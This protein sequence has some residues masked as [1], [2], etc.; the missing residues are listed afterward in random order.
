MKL[1]YYSMRN[2]FKEKSYRKCGGKLF[3]KNQV[4]HIS[5]S[6]VWIFIQLVCI[7]CLSRGL[8]KCIEIIEIKKKGPGTSC[9]ASF[10]VWFFKKNILTLYS[11]N[12]T[13]LI[14]W[15]SLPLEILGNMYIEI[16]CFSVYDAMNFE[17]NVS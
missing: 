14:V 16:V 9:P 13:N 2:I 10:S 8:Q 17:I 15:L 3:S 5:G 12:L 4:E 6:I 11:I 7:V 1:G